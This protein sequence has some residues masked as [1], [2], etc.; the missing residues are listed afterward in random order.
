MKDQRSGYRRVVRHLRRESEARPILFSGEMVRAILDER[1]TQTRRVIDLRQFGRSDTPGYEWHFRDRRALWNDVS[2][3]LLVDKFC[4]YGKPGDRIGV[5]ETWHELDPDMR[6]DAYKGKYEITG[7]G[8]RRAVNCV[9]Y[10]AD[11][12]RES[13]GIRAEYGYKWRP[14]IHMP[15]WASR[16]TLEIK[17]VR[18]ERLQDISNAD[19]I[20][21]GLEFS[22][23][24]GGTYRC[25][26]GL[27][28]SARGA[29]FRLWDSINGKKPGRSWDANPWVWAIE[30]RRVA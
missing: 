11:C 18:V 8:G 3:H 12:D 5:R 23:S 28:C 19:A 1:K 9:S 22:E 27:V 17:S 4:P 21:E 16:I 25:P 13:D 7:I 14:S 2:T 10:R 30:F 26:D 24:F 15:R 29:F 6:H 20:A